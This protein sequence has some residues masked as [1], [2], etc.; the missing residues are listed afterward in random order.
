MSTW[1]ANW[2][3]GATIALAVFAVVGTIFAIKNL[4][5]LNKKY[6]YDILVSLTDQINTKEERRNRAIIHSAWARS[7][8]ND[9]DVGDKIISLFE[10]VWEAGKS[11]RPISDE[12]M[13]LKNAIEETV[14]S[15][16][17]IGYF[18]MERDKA[19]QKETPIQIWSIADDMWNKLGT[20]VEKRHGERG[21]VW[22]TYFKK[23]GQEARHKMVEW[24]SNK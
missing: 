23:L 21:E 16:N 19:L 10:D 6:R 9:I 17:K 11:R 15:L 13:Q 2:A 5:T 3:N 4:W 14:A 24:K 12:K 1:L 18:L 7:N 20:F 8:W 22:A